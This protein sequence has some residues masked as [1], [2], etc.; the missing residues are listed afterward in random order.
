VADA[1]DAPARSRDCFMFGCMV[2]RRC[3]AG[4]TVS[5]QDVCWTASYREYTKWHSPAYSCGIQTRGKR[6]HRSL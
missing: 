2:A 1:I 5:Y 3:G 6:V 4:D